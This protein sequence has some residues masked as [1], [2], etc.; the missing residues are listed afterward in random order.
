MHALFFG[1]KRAYHGTLRIMREPLK[2]YQLTAARFDMLWVLY[3]SPFQ[4]ARQSMLRREL[5]VTAPTVSRMVKSLEALGFVRTEHDGFDRRQRLVTLT[6]KGLYQIRAAAYWFIRRKF[7]QLTINC[8]LG[9]E[10][11][12]SYGRVVFPAMC[13]FED[14]LYCI[15]EAFGDRA[16]LHYPWHPDD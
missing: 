12:R 14:L 2:V 15:R 4:S 16:R 7:A 6:K 5:G 8:A 13:V 11:W 9:R 1:M 3:R 10:E